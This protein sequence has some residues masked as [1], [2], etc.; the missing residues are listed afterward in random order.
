MDCGA[1]V[2][3]CPALLCCWKDELHAREEL[4][5][6]LG[7]CHGGFEE[8]EAEVCAGATAAVEE[9]EGLFVRLE[10]WDR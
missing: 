1:V 2:S 8:F 7:G 10:G 9:D 3:S 5:E 4:G 6:G